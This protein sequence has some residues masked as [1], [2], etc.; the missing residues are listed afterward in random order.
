M[1]ETLLTALFLVISAAFILGFFGLIIVVILAVLLPV[2]AQ[3]F[4]AIFA[5]IWSYR[6]IVWSLTTENGT[7]LTVS[8]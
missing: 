7:Q 6:L 2:I 4:V 8:D 3:V 5:C 1:I